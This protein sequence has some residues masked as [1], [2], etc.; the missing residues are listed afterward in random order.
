MPT[1]RSEPS[2]T[3]KG[4]QGLTD[5]GIFE[6][7]GL[8]DA[9]DLIT[10]WMAEVPTDRGASSPAEGGDRHV[11]VVHRRLG[12]GQVDEQP[13]H[14][15]G[16]TLERGQTPASAQPRLDRILTFLHLFAR[17]KSFYRPARRLVRWPIR[18]ARH[19]SCSVTAPCL[20]PSA[21]IQGTA[22]SQEV[23]IGPRESEF[24]E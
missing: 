4:T 15:R 8:A 13:C 23:I 9:I 20:H 24:Q 5:R 3:C 11:E 14:L 1:G 19:Q 7:I 2:S 22:D 12:Q 21:K 16:P 18:G 10:S 6:R 17:E